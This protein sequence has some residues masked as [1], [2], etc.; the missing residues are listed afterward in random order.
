MF[1]ALNKYIS[2]A[3]GH[4]K[5][6][7][8]PDLPDGIEHKRAFRDT[9]SKK[10]TGPV[11]PQPGRRKRQTCYYAGKHNRIMYDCVNVMIVLVLV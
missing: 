2:V 10:L 5:A 6:S 9:G 7:A 1:L 11:G 4:N 3:D 8:V